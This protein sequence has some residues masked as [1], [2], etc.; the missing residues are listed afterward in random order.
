MK[1]LHLI[2][3][4]FGAYWALRLIRKLVSLGIDVHVA[5]PEGGP[6]VG[7]YCEVGATEH[8][9]QTDF[10]IRTPWT[11]PELSRKFRKLVDEVKPDIIHSH[12]VGTTL[13]MRLALGRAHPVPRVFQVPGPLHLEHTFFRAAEIATAGPADYWIGTCQWTC[14]RYRQSRVENSRIF[15]CYYGTDIDAFECPSKG[16]LRKEVG[17]SDDTVIIG[18]VAFMYAPKRYLGQRRGLKGHEDLIDAIAICKEKVPDLRCVMVGGPPSNALSYEKK[19]IKYARKKCGDSVI[20]L[21]TRNDVPDLYVDFNVVAHPSHSENVG[22]AAE[23]LLLGV[24]TIAT[25][26]GGFPDLIRDGI[27]G[28][29]VPAKSPISL[30]SAIMDALNNPI[31]ARKRVTAGQLLTKELFDVNRTAAELSTIYQSILSNKN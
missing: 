17:V 8:L 6:M 21:G 19:L 23:S 18:M 2:K 28:W 20:F 3:T 5:L 10:P 11:F 13:T 15:L 25:R 9:L 29:L 26:V 27:T 14:E 4:S 30:A 24:P 12:F 7:R 16:R 31:E 22:G 1:A